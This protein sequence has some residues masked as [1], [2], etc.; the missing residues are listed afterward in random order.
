MPPGAENDALPC[1]NRDGL[2]LA[3]GR[4]ASDT[5][6][7]TGFSDD[8]FEAVLEQEL[9]TE[10][11]RGSLQRPHDCGPV[12]ARRRQRSDGARPK[13]ALVSHD[14]PVT[15]RVAAIRQLVGK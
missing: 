11:F 2:P 14:L 5:P 12:C 7:A 4:N 13:R 15:R 8:L 6:T 3:A 10:L 1:L 9:D